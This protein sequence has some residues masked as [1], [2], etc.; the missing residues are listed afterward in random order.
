MLQDAVIR[1][2]EIIG[3]AANNIDESF[4]K[5]YSLIPWDKMIGIRNRLIHEYF[6]VNKKIVRRTCQK[7]L[8]KL[9]ELIPPLL[10]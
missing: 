7:N 9:K 8:K 4:R 10:K 5:K 6:G 2:I 1:E 3:E